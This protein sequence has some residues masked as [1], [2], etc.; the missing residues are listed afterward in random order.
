MANHLGKFIPNLAQM[1]EPIRSLLSTKNR[2]AWETPQQEAF[3]KIKEALASPPVLAH[4]SLNAETVV[5]ADASSY[6]LGA[7]LMQ[8]TI[9]ESEANCLCFVFA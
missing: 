7:V 4:Y 1:K 5:S 6:G 9:R 3:A 8:R 2:W